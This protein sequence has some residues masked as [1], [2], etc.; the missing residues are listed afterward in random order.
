MADHRCI[1]NP[2]DDFDEEEKYSY[3]EDINAFEKQIE[4]NMEEMKESYPADR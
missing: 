2:F 1:R 4:Q 3:I